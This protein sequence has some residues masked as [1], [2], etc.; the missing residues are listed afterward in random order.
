MGFVGNTL[1]VVQA[2]ALHSMNP[3]DGKYKVLGKVGDWTGH[4]S[5]ASS[6]TDLHIIQDEKLWRVDP[7]TGQFSRLGDSAWKNPAYLASAGGKLL[8]LENSRF[9]IIDKVTG[10]YS[11]KGGQDWSLTTAFAA[12]EG[13]A[14]AIE[15]DRLWRINIDAGS[16]VHLSDGW[17]GRSVMVAAKGLRCD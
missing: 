1:F 4:T 12:D 7:A 16:F 14:F 2:G 17:S 10:G 8:A 6:S 9:H 15:S 13:M 3:N 11:V 5:M